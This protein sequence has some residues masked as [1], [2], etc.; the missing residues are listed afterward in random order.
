MGSD[1]GCQLAD[2]WAQLVEIPLTKGAIRSISSGFSEGCWRPARRALSHQTCGGFAYSGRATKARWF[3]LMRASTPADQWAVFGA[4]VNNL[5]REIRKVSSK[6]HRR[7]IRVASKGF[8]RPAG[9][10]PQAKAD[11]G[12]ELLVLPARPQIYPLTAFPGLTGRLQVVTR[13]RSAL[14]AWCDTL[15]QG[16]RHQSSTSGGGARGALAQASARRLKLRFR[17]WRLEHRQRH[18]FDRLLPFRHRMLASHDQ[19]RRFN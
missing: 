10:L 19:D 7:L 14:Q 12:G 11:S 13:P 4:S 9:G 2:P 3:N 5:P 16:G 15:E 6:G 17:R 1:I 18:S 8:A